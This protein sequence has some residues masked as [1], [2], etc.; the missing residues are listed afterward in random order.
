MIVP[1][2]KK[3]DKTKNTSTP[4]NPPGIKFGHAWKITTT[5]TAIALNPSISDLYFE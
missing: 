2:I 1:V 4:T 3:P 5:P